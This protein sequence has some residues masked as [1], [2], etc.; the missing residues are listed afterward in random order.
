MGPGIGTF[1]P[2]GSSVRHFTATVS[3][4]MLEW[5]RPGAGCSEAGS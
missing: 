3:P 1:S 4:G 5:I 2:K